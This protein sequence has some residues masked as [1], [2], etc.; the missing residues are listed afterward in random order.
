MNSKIRTITLQCPLDSVGDEL[1]KNFCSGLEIFYNNEYSPRT[2][3][4]VSNPITT[5]DSKNQDILDKYLELSSKYKF[6][7][8]CF[9]FELFDEDCSDS[10]KL[11]SKVVKNENVFINLL[12]INDK[13]I[14]FSGINNATR[15]IIE[16]SKNPISNFRVGV[17]SEKIQTPFFPFSVTDNEIKFTVGLEIVGHLTEL[18]EENNRLDIDSL[19]DLL[20]SSIKSEAENI[21][22]LC[23]EF[24]EKTGIDYRGIDISLAPY[25]YPLE[26]QSVVS[27]IES[28]GRIAR[29]RGEAIFEFGSNGT[30]FI[31]SYL[32]DIL[33]FVVKN[34]DIKTT[35]FNGVM[36]S[37][38]EDTYLS[39]SYE[40]DA[41]DIDF[42]KLLS[43]TCG[44][45]VDMVPLP[46]NVKDSSITGI[47][48]DV[49]SMS[50]VL[51]KPLG[52]R[53]LPIPGL[54]YG[55]KTNF[56]HL[57]I[58]NTEVKEIKEGVTFQYLPQQKHTFKFKKD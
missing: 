20:I 12:P 8:V 21:Q 44:C 36:Y 1:L 30:H 43:T 42:L 57:F 15:F 37:L 50:L 23:L 26:D 34:S 47:I 24:S 13:F 16:N 25:P 2:Y 18:V 35:G 31:N 32:T 46:G 56:K 14:N 33:K 5:E 10:I 19:R 22:K 38:L 17:S 6:W 45:G 53:V 3:R 39:R 52:V 28:I 48:M 27:L 58:T 49:M 51:N 54:R 29:S 55:E 40:N 41:F 7:G 9:P 11:A 4:I